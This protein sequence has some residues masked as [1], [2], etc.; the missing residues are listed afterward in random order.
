[1]E[2]IES[3]SK[4]LKDSTSDIELKHSNLRLVNHLVERHIPSFGLI[5]QYS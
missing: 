5:F 2:L 1:M 3:E 4:F